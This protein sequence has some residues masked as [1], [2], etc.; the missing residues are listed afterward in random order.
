MLKI[1]INADDFGCNKQ[2]TEEIQRLLLAK[3]I[4]STTI[5]ANGRFLNNAADFALKHPEFSYGAHLCLSE[6]ASLT[7]S[8]TLKKYGIIDE[9]GDFVKFRIFQIRHFP[10]DL[11]L[12]IKQELIQQITMLKEKGLVLSHIDSHHHVHT[13][14][15][16]KNIFVEIA[17]QFQ[18]KYIRRGTEFNSFRA[19]LH[20]K[21]FWE[22]R[23]LNKYYSSELITT[24]LF[25]PFSQISLLFK[26][27][28]IRIV[29]LMCHPGNTENESFSTEIQQIENMQINYQGMFQLV[30][31][32]QL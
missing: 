9:R 11:L 16:L 8:D 26:K 14:Y 18:I 22:R 30:N 19:K 5:M 21:Q 23:A 12:A 25:L 24:D 1:I 7:Q 20:I 32:N 17:K 28:S 2:I 10:E 15:P 31:Y 4:T 3:K 27:Q 29:E 6:F 13:I